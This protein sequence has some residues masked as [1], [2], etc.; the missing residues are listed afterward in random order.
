MAKQN[1]PKDTKSRLHPRSAHRNNYDFDALIGKE[2]ELKLFVAPNKYGTLSIDF[3]NQDAVRSL[4]KAL[5]KTHYGIDDW[6]LPKQYLCPP[7][8]GRADYIHYIADLIGHIEPNPYIKGL[9]IGTG[10]NC[11]YPL[12]GQSVYQWNFV[13]SDVDSVAIDSAQD[14]IKSN[15]LSD[16][17]ELRLQIEGNFKFKNIIKTNETFHFSMC[18]PPFHASAEE[19]RKQNRKKV[20]NLK[21]DKNAKSSLNFG[22]QSNEL[23]CKGGEFR[24]IKDMLFES[25]H[26]KHQVEWFTTLVSKG[27]NLKPLKTFLNKIEPKSVE[28][29]E[30]GQGQK[31]SRILAWSFVK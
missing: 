4:N 8:P 24:F 30:M 3:F 25:R 28:I 12:I 31:S 11:I 20:Q 6:T 21:D 26:Y 9:D 5:L 14:I 1:P 17:I 23:W 2:P 15:S 16:S 10:A 13:G 19:A 29:I 7:I 18:N 27:S 22:G